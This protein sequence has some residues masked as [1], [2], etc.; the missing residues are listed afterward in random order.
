[1]RDMSSSSSQ[2]GTSEL[3]SRERRLR[4]NIDDITSRFRFEDF[5][6]HRGAGANSTS[7]SFF[8]PTSSSSSSSTVL[9]PSEDSIVSLMGLGFE[10]EVVIR[11]LQSTGNNIEA[12]A[13]LLLR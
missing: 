3:R 10:R 5:E 7:Q 8:R 4:N 12:A 1:M 9:P 11:A 2:D 13:N 6:E